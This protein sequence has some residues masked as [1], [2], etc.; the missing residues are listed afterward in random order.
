MT[1]LRRI[2]RPFAFLIAAQ[3]AHSVEE[4]WYRLYDRLAPARFVAELFSH[5]LARGFAVAN[6]LL[7]LAGVGGIFVV[8]RGGSAARGV[9]WFWAVLEIVNGVNHIAFALVAGGY[10][11]G[12]VTA[13]LLLG[14]GAYLVRRLSTA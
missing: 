7:V 13:P 10:F 6:T 1:A 5:D 4:C 2:T 11:P 8:R 3:A 9:A 12:L 14:S